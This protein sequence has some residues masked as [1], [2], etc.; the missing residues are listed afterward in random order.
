MFLR[1]HGSTVVKVA[2]GFV[3]NLVLSSIKES[4]LITQSQP[5]GQIY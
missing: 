5:E 4:S 3:P 1:S 2:T